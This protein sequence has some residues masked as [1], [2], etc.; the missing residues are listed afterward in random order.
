MPFAKAGLVAAALSICSGP[1]GRLAFQVYAT[2]GGGA[3]IGHFSA[4]H[5]I[6]SA[7][8]WTSALII[9]ALSEAVIRTGVLSW[10]ALGVRRGAMHL[11]V[12]LTPAPRRP[13]VGASRSIMGS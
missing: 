8:A 5:S 6:T 10:R 7:A 12:G 4:A 3:A 13:T 11:P 1:G 9:M 2:H